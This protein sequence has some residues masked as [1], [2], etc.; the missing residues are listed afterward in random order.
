ME[1]RNYTTQDAQE[2][3]KASE[4][5][6]ENGFDDWSE[7]G[8]RRNADLMDE[9]FQQNRTIPVTVA[10]I[11]K[12][13]EQNKTRFKWV[14]LAEA[15]YGK[16]AN[17]QPDRANQLAAWLASQGKAGQLANTGEA[18]YENLAQLL[19]AL[20]GY[21]INPARIC[22]AENRIANKPG[23]KLHYV[24]EP[25]RTGPRSEAAK[26]DDGVP[27]LGRNLNEPEWVRRSRE[28]SEREAKEA[29][30]QPS[31][32]SVRAAA[33]RE[34]KRQAQ[35]LR[36]ATH[37]ESDQLQKIFVTEGTEIDWPGTYAARLAL[38]KNFQKSQAVRRFIR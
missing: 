7:E 34:A 5:L 17:Q 27:F 9:Y 11:Y 15:A 31:S 12:A 4:Q 6:R 36:G 28:R 14:S 37:S 38:Q 13:V 20:T 25:R 33:I 24:P 26:A 8:V 29:A 1:R 18:A 10:N 19:Q 35:E 22:D 16:I 23:K 21:D 32:V 2:F 30:N 3:E